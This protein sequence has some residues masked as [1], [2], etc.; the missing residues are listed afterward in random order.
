MWKVIGVI[1]VSILLGIATWELCKIAEDYGKFKGEKEGIKEYRQSF[2]ITRFRSLR[3]QL[4][5]ITGKMSTDTWYA[6]CRIAAK[7]IKANRRWL[8]Q[9]TYLSDVIDTLH[10]SRRLQQNIDIRG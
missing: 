2:S 5:D 7:N 4:E 9:R 3:Q 6:I 1:G 10:K 8:G